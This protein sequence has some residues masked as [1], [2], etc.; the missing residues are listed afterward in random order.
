MHDN[1][2]EYNLNYQGNIMYKRIK[3]CGAKRVYMTTIKCTYIPTIWYHFVVTVIATAT[4]FFS[5]WQ[6]KIAISIIIIC[7]YDS[8]YFQEFEHTFQKSLWAYVK[9]LFLQGIELELRK[10]EGAVEAIHENLLY[11]K[12]R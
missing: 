9:S 10:L 7:Y 5:L 3:N 6:S 4:T 2:P 11:L 12:N 8:S 1:T